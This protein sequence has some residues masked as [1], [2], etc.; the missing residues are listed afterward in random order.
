MPA[1]TGALIRH[2]EERER[3]EGKLP[4]LL[5]FYQKLLRVQDKVEQRLASRL[6]PSL[7]REAIIWRIERGIPLIAFAELALD[8]PLLIDTFSEVTAIFSDHAE[9]FNAPPESWRELKADSL[10]TRQRVKAWFEKNKLPATIS[11]KGIS[12][13]LLSAIIHAVLKPFL[14]SH[15][16]TLVDSIDQERWRRS[17]CPICGGSPDFAFLDKER[18]SRWL[19]CSRCDTE[20]LF[21]RLQCPFCGTEDQNALSYFTD[22]K[23]LYRLYV[24][25]RCKH[26]LKTIDLRQ[27]NDEV[28]LPLER[29]YTLDLDRQAK[30]QGYRPYDRPP[31]SAKEVDKTRHTK[32]N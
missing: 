29:L 26:Y 23:G 19:K 7:N 18:G 13:T 24:C 1:E 2:L 31:R 12:K 22:E 9:L 30:E 15:A 6:A 17:Y 32:K 5:Q 8:W 21:Q 10:L 20:W 14:V 11:V 25:E 16:R 27:A 28:L 4:Q 3:K